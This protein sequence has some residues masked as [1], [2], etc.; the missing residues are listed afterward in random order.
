MKAK[1]NRQR[2]R[3]SQTHQHFSLE[4]LSG[5]C[6]NACRLQVRLSAVWHA[7]A[8]VAVN[9]GKYLCLLQ[10]NGT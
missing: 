1:A 8:F 2:R 6:G 9:A 7:G 5:C 3:W 4:K 10:F